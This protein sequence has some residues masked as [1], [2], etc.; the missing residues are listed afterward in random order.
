MTS[1]GYH[2]DDDPRRIDVDALWDFLS[3]QAYWAR[4]RTRADVEA[5][6]AAAWRVIGAYDVATGAMVGFARAFSD[7]AALA[8]L[9]DV[10]V[11]PGH[12]GHGLGHALVAAMV[13]EG[14][15][16]AYRWLLHT[17]DAHGLYAAH[18]FAPP[19]HTLL[20]RPRRQPGHHS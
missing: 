6:L 7:G 1:T 8:Y 9:A 17:E 5:Q 19:D 18:G 11:L 2:L 14:P 16:S 13:D 4:W 15:G 10:Y 12:R 20:E 3:N